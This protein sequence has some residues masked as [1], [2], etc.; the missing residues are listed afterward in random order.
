MKKGV[1]I[2]CFPAD[3]SLEQCFKLAKESGYDGLELNMVEESSQSPALKPDGKDWTA[4]RELSVKY[5]L[6]VSS[7]STILHWEYPL[8][9]SNP[10]KSGRG[11][12]LVRRMIDAAKFLGSDTVL[13]VPG[14]V[15]P[16]VSYKSAYQRSL[17]AFL[18][19][20]CYAEEH[21]IIIGIENVWNKFLLSPLEMAGFIDRI[22]S[23]Y[24]KAYFDAGN[25]LQFSYPEH[26]IEILD[27]R[28]AKVHIK[29]FDLSIG[30][31]SGFKNLLHGHLDWKK[32]NEALL[33]IGYDDYVTAELNPH[34]QYPEQLIKDTKAA[35]DVIFGT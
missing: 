23:N 30:S 16:T 5:D 2:C 12:E 34:M 10:A 32:L 20:K 3:Y 29:D 27:K 19:L 17:D 28:I 22:D 1:N 13:I 21:E 6:P 18:E 25:V 26:W 24:V 11:K 31:I 15:T 33:A 7:I 8:T 14:E 35:M 9:D 4:I